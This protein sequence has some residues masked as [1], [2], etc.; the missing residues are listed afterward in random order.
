MLVS[1]VLFVRDFRLPAYL[2]TGLVLLGHIGVVVLAFAL[3]LTT[4][5][6]GPAGAVLRY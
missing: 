6:K 2:L 5:P 4:W 1:A 3:A